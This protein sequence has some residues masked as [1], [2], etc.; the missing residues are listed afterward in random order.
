[1]GHF[2]VRRDLYS[3]KTASDITSETYSV[4]DARSI[5]FFIS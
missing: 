4:K 1:M 3:S 5:T 2:T